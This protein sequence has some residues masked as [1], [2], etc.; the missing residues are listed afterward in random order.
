MKAMLGRIWDY[1]WTKGTRENFFGGLILL[2]LT[3]GATSL[4]LWSKSGFSHSAPIAWAAAVDWL[5]KSI[6]VSHGLALLLLLVAGAAVAVLVRRKRR[7]YGKQIQ[8]INDTHAREIDE[9]TNH[10][11]QIAEKLRGSELT[12]ER[13]EAELAIYKKQLLEVYNPTKLDATATL[14]LR[15]LFNKYPHPDDTD[16]LAR[17]LRISYATAETACNDLKKIGLIRHL[18]QTYGSMT[19]GWTMSADGRDYGVKHGF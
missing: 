2:L 12:R 16:D 11:K 1:V 18:P 8:S 3:T 14:V 10:Q 5:A 15:H 7:Q 6:A 17:Q 19:R 13:A 9:L 4:W